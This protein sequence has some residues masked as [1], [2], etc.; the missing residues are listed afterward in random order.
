MN[1]TA[2]PSA[3]I[4]FTN[5]GSCWAT[6][7]GSTCPFGRTVRSTP[8][9]PSGFNTFPR[10][11]P[12]SS[13]RCF[14]KKQIVPRN[15]PVV[16]AP[17]LLRGCSQAA[18]PAAAVT[19]TNSRLVGTGS[20]PVVQHVAHAAAVGRHVAAEPPGAVGIDRHGLARLAAI[21]R[22]RGILV[23]RHVRGDGQVLLVH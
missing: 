8:S 4:A 15:P 16:P 2:S 21:R 12:S 11:R 19:W 5:T 9:N 17:R 14:E 22:S 3:R 23:N 7:S 18:A 10:P 6:R 20:P 1:G 13:G